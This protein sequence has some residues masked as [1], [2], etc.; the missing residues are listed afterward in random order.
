MNWD[1]ITN[2]ILIAAFAVLAVFALLGLCQLIRRKSLKK[3]DPA[4]SKML[5]PLILT[6]LIY[7]IFDKFLILNTRPDGSGE[8]SFPSTHVLIVATIFSLTAIAL[9]KYLKSRATRLLFE[10]LML[11]LTVLVALGRVYAQKHWPSDVAGALVF[12]ALN[13]LIYYLITKEKK[14]E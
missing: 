9:P 5:V 2:V 13:A 6:A 14:H 8:P 12:A 7:V 10:L 11:A 3:V 4:L 1:L